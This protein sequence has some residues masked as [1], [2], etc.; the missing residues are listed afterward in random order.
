MEI[1]PGKKRL[2]IRHAKFAIIIIFIV[3]VSGLLTSGFRSNTSHEKAWVVE[4]N[5]KDSIASVDAFMKVYQVLKS[6]RC[7][8][9]HPAGDIPLQGDDSHLHTMSPIRGKD[10]KGVY[11]MKC[12]NCHQPN[13]SAGLNTPPGNPKWALPPEDMKMVFE[14]KS[15]RELALQI[16]DYKRNGHKN[17]AQLLE[18]A[19][20]T[21][22][23]AGWNMGAGRKPPP[24]SY[25]EFVAAWDKWNNNGGVAPK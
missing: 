8:N 12:S 2:N 19:R 18:H 22:V 4:V 24:L 21:L 23:K 13:N 14:G 1:K 3:T 20:D 15:P 9:C 25:K 16:M 7:M 17:K 5:N 6:P 10:G 11:A